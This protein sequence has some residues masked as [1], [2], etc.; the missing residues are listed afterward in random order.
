[1]F[2][3]GAATSLLV[4]SEYILTVLVLFV[5]AKVIVHRANRKLRTEQYLD[6]AEIAWASRQTVVP[7]LVLKGHPIAILNAMRVTLDRK[8]VV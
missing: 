4:L 7:E 6:F 1:M 3:L 2:T 8:S 5:I